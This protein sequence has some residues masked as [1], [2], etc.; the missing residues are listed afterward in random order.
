[1][2]ENPIHRDFILKAA[3]RPIV[4]INETIKNLKRYL[5]HQKQTFKGPILLIPLGS[6]QKSLTNIKALVSI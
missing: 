4:D 2:T 3:N 1:M 5:I 6:I